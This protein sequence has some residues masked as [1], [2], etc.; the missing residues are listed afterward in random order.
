MRTDIHF[1]PATGTVIGMATVIVTGPPGPAGP[2]GPIGPTGPQGPAA[3]TSDIIQFVTV[4][5]YP[6]A[7]LAATGPKPK[8]I[9]VTTDTDGYAS[10]YEYWPDSTAIDKLE[11]IVTG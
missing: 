1:D 7:V 2:Q 11:W 8:R 3:D 5:N 6:A 10:M 4:A 9:R